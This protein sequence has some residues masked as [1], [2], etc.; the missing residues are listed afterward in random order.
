MY[1]NKAVFLSDHRQEASSTNCDGRELA[2]AIPISLRDK[3]LE[4]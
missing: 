4:M 1:E 2:T 3:Y